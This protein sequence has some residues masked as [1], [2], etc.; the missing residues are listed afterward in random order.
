[1]VTRIGSI[2]FGTKLKFAHES[3]MPGFV[4]FYRADLLKFL[5]FKFL[6]NSK[7]CNITQ[8]LYGLE[9][10]PWKNA[11]TSFRTTM[12][13]SRL[14]FWLEKWKSYLEK[15][16]SYICLDLLYL[17]IGSESSHFHFNKFWFPESLAQI[18]NFR[19]KF[20]DL[21]IDWFQWEWFQS[22]RNI[23]KYI[24]LLKKA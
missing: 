4:P 24:S 10:Q 8:P 3:L 13:Y 18:P 6:R 22:I 16:V 19:S 17:K 23:L 15:K 1:M 9:N 5:L 2:D 14:Y 12:G 21:W 7:Q 11:Y 20:F